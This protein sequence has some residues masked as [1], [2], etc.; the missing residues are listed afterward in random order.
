MSEKYYVHETSSGFVVYQQ[1]RNLPLPFLWSSRQ[2]ADEACEEFNK[3]GYKEV[4]RYYYIAEVAGT[5]DISH[6]IKAGINPY[7]EWMDKNGDMFK[8]REY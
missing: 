3:G 5:R 8:P 7:R 4:A 6:M 1:G 2:Y